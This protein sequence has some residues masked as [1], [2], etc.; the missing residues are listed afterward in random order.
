VT[1]HGPNKNISSST[2]VYYDDGNFTRKNSS[3]IG[4]DTE[5]VK[6][7]GRVMFEISSTRVS[8]DDVDFP[9]SDF[10]SFCCHCRKTLHGKDVYMYRGEK[11]FC[12]TECRH[13]EIVKDERKEKQQCTSKLVAS[14]SN[15]T[16]DYVS[17]NLPYVTDR[18][19]FAIGIFAT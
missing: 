17:T 4:F 10:L 5:I 8:D 2:R 16:T 7:H 11:A 3:N 6:K 18:R 1:C 19:V 12:S 13:V 9:D 14:R 15:T